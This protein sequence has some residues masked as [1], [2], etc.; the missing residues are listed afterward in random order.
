V[1]IVISYFT[2]ISTEHV[3]SYFS[4]LPSISPAMRK[5]MYIWLA[6]FG[7]IFF[8]SIDFWAWGSSRLTALG[9]PWWVWYFIG[10]NLLLVVAMVVFSKSYWK[11]QGEKDS[12]S[13]KEKEME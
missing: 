10:L 5:M 1:L 8:L 11:P 13:L 2:S 9:F 12:S 4:D 3:K 7:V 6:I